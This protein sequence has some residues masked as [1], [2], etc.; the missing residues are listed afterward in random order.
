MLCPKVRWFGQ[1]K[2]PMPY[3]PRTCFARSLKRTRSSPAH[4]LLEPLD[5][6]S[7]T[8][9]KGRDFIGHPLSGNF[10]SFNRCIS[11][12]SVRF[13]RRAVGFQPLGR[14]SVPPIVGAICRGRVK[15]DCF[16][17]APDGPSLHECWGTPVLVDRKSELPVWQGEANM[18]DKDKT[19]DGTP[20]SIEGVVHQLLQPLPNRP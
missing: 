3:R 14:C 19:A 13:H 15:N 20:L 5:G 4:Q 1:A 2:P 6:R 17:E 7:N 8:Q 9:P 11:Y 10:Y 18:N 12:K 16:R